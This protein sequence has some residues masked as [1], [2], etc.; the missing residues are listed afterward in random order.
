MLPTI[1]RGIVS[2]V[3]YADL[4]DPDSIPIGIGAF[5]LVGREA[6]ETSGGHRRF[7]HLH[8]DDTLLAGS[9]RASGGRVDLAIAPELMSIRLYCGAKQIFRTSVVKAR[10]YS[11]DRLSY[12]L[13]MLSAFSLSAALPVP[14]ASVVA[15]AMIR[16]GT[17]EPWACGYVGAALLVYWQLSRQY[18]GIELV[19]DV[20]PWTGWFHPI[21]GWGRVAIFVTTTFQI[22]TGSRRHWRG[23][24]E[25]GAE[26]KL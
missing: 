26:G 15:A 5:M 22:L 6:Y 17:I 4:N 7:P 14:L 16:T 19:T 20:K 3:H 9:V 18:R 24:H 23:R 25:S 21:A 13:S 11:G 2:A 1:W 12:P 8:A 10:T